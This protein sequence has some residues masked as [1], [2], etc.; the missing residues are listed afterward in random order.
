MLPAADAEPLAQSVRVGWHVV[1]LLRG[2]GGD[3]A[4]CIWIVRS[5]RLAVAHVDRH[6]PQPRIERQVIQLLVERRRRDRQHRHLGD[7]T[8]VVG[9]QGGDV[10]RQ[11]NRPAHVLVVVWRDGVVEAKPARVELVAIRPGEVSEPG[12]GG[13]SAV[14]Q[15]FEGV[16]IQIE[17][18]VELVAGHGDDLALAR[19]IKDGQDVR[20][21]SLT[22]DHAGRGLLP[23]IAA[24]EQLPVAIRIGVH[25]HVRAERHGWVIGERLEVRG[26]LPH[27]LGHH[28]DGVVA[29]GEV[30]VKAR[31]GLIQRED[32]G[33]RIGRGDGVD[34]QLHLG[35]EH[36]ARV[37][38]QRV[39]GEGDV[40]GGELQPIA[41]HDPASQRHGHGQVVGAVRGAISRQRVD[42]LAGVLIDIPQVV[43]HQPLA[44]W[45]G[46]T[47]RYEHVEV[48]GDAVAADLV[49]HVDLLA[50]DRNRQ[51][52]ATEALCERYGH[53]ATCHG[54]LDRRRCASR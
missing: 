12:A 16:V 11:R 45:H 25:R 46:R 21:S 18:H 19:S 29:S 4:R 26:V 15:R 53:R 27:V 37:V 20:R 32:D 36:Q 9:V 40:V 42:P 22:G 31:V 28:V 17:Q 50:W 51:A 7:T 48:V 6:R 14:D 44:G 49:D 23:V 54:Q 33:I 34:V 38:L 30:E 35:R 52:A 39:D 24:L 13:W 2:K 41:P 1:A 8:D 5:E 10:Q 43:H 47:A 3:A